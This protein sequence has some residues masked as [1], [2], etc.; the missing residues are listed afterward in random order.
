MAATILSNK[1]GTSVV[2]HAASSNSTIVVA[3]NNSVSNIASFDENL[4]GAY[5]TQAV[6]GCDGT[7][8]INLKRGANLVAVF[9]ST[10][11]HDYAGSGMALSL[12]N[13][14][15]VNIEF[16]NSANGFIVFELQKIGST[17][18]QAIT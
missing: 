18:S 12:Y 17:S 1:R 7:G 4:T 3:G 6:W 11:Q 13:A 15:N 16:I 5:L 8:Y 10:G 14:A 2:I 9:D